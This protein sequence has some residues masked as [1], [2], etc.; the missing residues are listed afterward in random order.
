MNL[1]PLP[2]SLSRTINQLVLHCSATASGRWLPD[3][4]PTGK[5]TAVQVIDDWH[6]ARGFKRSEPSRQRFNT[7]LTSIGY[8]YVVDLDGHVWTG[9][10]LE[11][12]GA[13]VAGHN[14]YSIGVCLIG[15]AEREG[16]YTPEQWESLAALVVQLKGRFSQLGAARAIVGHR[17]LSPD[18]N[19]DGKVSSNEWLKTCPGFDVAGWLIRGL[20]PMPANVVP[21]GL[22]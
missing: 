15:G 7:S 19:G 8:H 16:R 20:K 22:Q 12:V 9:R 4:G 13:H 2:A 18:A 11:E 10:H 14:T 3:A 17:D 5:R 1:P 21:G 6:R